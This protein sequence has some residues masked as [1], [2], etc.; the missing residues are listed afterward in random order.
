MCG[1]AGAITLNQQARPLLNV[2][3]EMTQAIAHRGPDDAALHF[4]LGTGQPGP[5]HVD[6]RV[7]PLGGKTGRPAGAGKRCWRRLGFIRNLMIFK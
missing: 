1:I 3:A 4:G 6:R 5:G 7:G 2:V